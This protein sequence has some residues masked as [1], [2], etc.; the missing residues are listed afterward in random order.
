MLYYNIICTLTHSHSHI[1]THSHTVAMG[2]G[3]DPHFSIILPSGKLLCFTVQGEHDFVFSLISTKRVSINSLFVAD[4]VREEITWMG[5]LGIVV[6]GENYHG[7]NKTSLRF[8]AKTKTVSVGAKLTL[9]AGGIDTLHFKN[10]KLMITEKDPED[11][12][13]D[14][15]HPSVCVNLEDVGLHFHVTFYGEHLDIFWSTVTIDNEGNQNI[16]G[17]V[18]EQASYSIHV[19]TFKY[20][21]A[22][23]Y[24][25]N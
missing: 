15:K 1:L 11:K 4:S 22:I 25:Y 10:G 6:Q 20:I 23:I 3:D 17:L 8:D 16:H 13:Q 7:E 18:G 9:E 24:M 5:A 14:L 12:G 2:G 19:C 21:A